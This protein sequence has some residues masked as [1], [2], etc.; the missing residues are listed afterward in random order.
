MNKTIHAASGHTLHVASVDRSQMPANLVH[1][2]N[3]TTFY[4][5][6]NWDKDGVRFFW[7]AK[8][9]PQAPGQIVVWFA[10]SGAFWAGFGK[11]MEAAINGAQADGWMY[12]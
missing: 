7:M 3:Y 6:R 4:E 2:E 11:T 10:K 9:N 5:V 8:G 12:A 1:A